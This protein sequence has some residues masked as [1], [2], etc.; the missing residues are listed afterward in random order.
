[1][2]KLI[3]LGFFS[4]A[5]HL[6]ALAQ[7]QDFE[8]YIIPKQNSR[9]KHF[10]SAA[11]RKLREQNAQGVEV[12]KKRLYKTIAPKASGFVSPEVDP[13]PCAAGKPEPC[14]VTMNNMRNELA[15]LRDQ[16]RQNT[17]QIAHLQRALEQSSIANRTRHARRSVN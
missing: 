4:I 13:H 7:K 3:I 8:K 1:M 2:K 15:E 12:R 5:I 17:A 10:Y 6:P 11:K 16:A 14:L 9:Y